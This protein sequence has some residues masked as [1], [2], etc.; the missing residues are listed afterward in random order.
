MMKDLPNRDS[1]LGENRSVPTQTATF[2]AKLVACADNHFVGFTSEYVQCPF[3]KRC[4]VS[5]PPKITTKP[6]ARLKEPN[7]LL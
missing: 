6:D 4:V 7:A 5:A 2:N 1:D 3:P